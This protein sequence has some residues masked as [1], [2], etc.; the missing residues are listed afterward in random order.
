MQKVSIQ[1]TNHCRVIDA[2]AIVGGKWK[3]V[4]LWQLCQKTQRFNEL[5]KAIPGITQKMLAQQLRQMEV[6][7]LIARKVYPQIP[8]KVEYSITDHGKSLQIVLNALN[9]WAIKHLPATQS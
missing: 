8:P 9:D 3:L 1:K 2:I 6:D 7:K 4:I 5:E